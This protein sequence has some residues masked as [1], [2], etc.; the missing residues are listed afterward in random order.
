MEVKCKYC[1]SLIDDK[2]EVCPNCGA[3]NESMK[4]MVDGTPK[5]IAELADWYK[6]RNLPPYEKTRF[7]IGIDYKLPKAFGIYEENGEFIVYKNKADG[8]RAIRYRGKDEAYAVNEIYLKLKSEILNQKS[9]NLNRSASY[10]A[11]NR[12]SSS[13]R[14]RRRREYDSGNFLTWV[15][16]IAGIYVMGNFGKLFVPLLAALIC[17]VGS[18]YLIRFLL[19]KFADTDL[20]EARA[21]KRVIIFI[22]IGLGMAGFIAGMRGTG[23]K[24]YKYGDSVYVDYRGNYYEYDAGWNDYDSIYSLPAEILANPSDY[25][26]S[27]TDD[28]WD[29]DYDFYDSDTYDYEY[30]SSDWSSDSDS[31]WDWSSDSDWDWDSGSDWDY[32]GSDW[33]SDW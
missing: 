18:Y 6:A 12:S 7:F 28:S 29:Y 21:L 10:N 25:S 16:I 23:P 19:H 13:S 32:G 20:S 14:R 26:F 15:W 27:W 5:T 22:C 9:N 3:V 17:G 11:Q 24:Y 2:L 4:R 33:G 30:S 1:G 31:D 8:S